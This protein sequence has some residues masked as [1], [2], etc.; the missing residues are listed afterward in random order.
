M[1]MTYKYRG[2]P[3]S[4]QPDGKLWCVS[5]ADR[6]GNGAGILEWCYDKKDAKRLMKAMQK[7]K[8]RFIQLRVEPYKRS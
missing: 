2:L 7:D 3:C 8:G 5:G 1:K 6:V 4:I